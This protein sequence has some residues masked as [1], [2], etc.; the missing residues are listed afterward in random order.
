MVIYK[1]GKFQIVE[2]IR[3]IINKMT[4]Q[5]K[6]RVLCWSNELTSAPIFGEGMGK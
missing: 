4:F 1:K 6:A 5:E 3:I 2:E